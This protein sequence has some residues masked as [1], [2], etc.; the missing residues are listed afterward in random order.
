MGFR[1]VCHWNLA[2]VWPRIRV[3]GGWAGQGRE[4][5]GNYGKGCTNRGAVG[6]LDIGDDA[7]GDD[8]TLVL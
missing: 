2:V 5:V 3:T 4:M 8:A 7:T 1:S 6:S